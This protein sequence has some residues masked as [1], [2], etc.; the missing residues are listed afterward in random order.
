MAKWVARFEMFTVLL[1][2]IQ[3]LLYYPEDKGKN[4]ILNSVPMC[5]SGW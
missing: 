1:M 5:Q 3:V 4:F 2:K